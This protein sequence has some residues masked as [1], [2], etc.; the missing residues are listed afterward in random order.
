MHGP[1][2]FLYLLDLI[3][4]VTNYTVYRLREIV[5]SKTIF[6]F[7][8][9]ILSDKQHT[10]VFRQEMQINTALIILLVEDKY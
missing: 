8:K 4:P 1:N 2:L 5:K 7:I 6:Q 10:I 3:T 9:I